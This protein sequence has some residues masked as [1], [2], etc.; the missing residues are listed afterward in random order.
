MR[1]YKCYTVI[2]EIT[3]EYQSHLIVTTILGFYPN[4]TFKVDN[5]FAGKLPQ[6]QAFRKLYF[7]IIIFG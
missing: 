2:T 4:E 1:R 5:E 7:T 6:I 3:Q